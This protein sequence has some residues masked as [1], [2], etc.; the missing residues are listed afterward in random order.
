MKKIKIF[1]VA[2]LCAGALFSAEAKKNNKPVE[3]KNI[4]DSITYY[5][6]TSNAANFKMKVVDKDKNFDMKS[7]IKGM[8][9]VG[10]MANEN[11]S[12]M[13]GIE[14]AMSA[15]DMKKQFNKQF[16]DDLNM[17]LFYE[18][19]CET[20]QKDSVQQYVDDGQQYV[21]P[22]MT[23]VVSRR[24]AKFK[25]VGDEFIKKEMAADPAYKMTPTGLVYKVIKEGNG[26]KFGSSDAILVDYTGSLIN[27]DVFD[28]SKGSPRTFSPSNVVPGFG[29]ALMMMSPGAVYRVYIPGNLAY[30]ERGM[31]QAGIGPNELLIFDITTVDFANKKAEKK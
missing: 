9:L 12:F 6:S 22:L 28:S 3:L 18:A 17:P 23:E 2:L 24:A 7:F 1:A 10:K 4:N 29:E 25:K 15:E 14:M 19:F 21:Q 20:V 31:A 5:L 11:E 30:G 26:D 8:E 27:G 16:G 13:K